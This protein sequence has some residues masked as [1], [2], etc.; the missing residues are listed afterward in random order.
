MPQKRYIAGLRLTSPICAYSNDEDDI[1][2]TGKELKDH[3]LTALGL[4]TKQAKNYPR[5][6]DLAVFLD[7]DL[8]WNS[9]AKKIDFILPNVAVR[10]DEL[11]AECT[12]KTKRPLTREE[13]RNLKK[14]LEG[15]Y[16]DGW[17]EVLAQDFFKL[18]GREYSMR[19]WTLD[20]HGFEV[21]RLTREDFEKQFP[22]VKKVPSRKQTRTPAGKETRKPLS[23]RIKEA[24][25]R[26]AEHGGKTT[27]REHNK[28]KKGEERR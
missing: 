2:L 27:G 4:F 7:L 6:N 23:A 11:V 13:E 28:E 12:V 16:A 15:Q 10:G 24:E 17:G 14:F 3:Y 26:K 5:G 21:T 19:L 8:S 1:L 25:S 22:Q 20:F 18:D 9:F